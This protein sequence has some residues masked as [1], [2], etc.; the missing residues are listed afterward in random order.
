ML[1]LQLTI[2]QILQRVGWVKYMT[3]W[4]NIAGDEYGRYKFSMPGACLV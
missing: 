1:H 4:E 2:E 3:T